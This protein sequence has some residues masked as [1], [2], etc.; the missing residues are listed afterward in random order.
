ML[1][2]LLNFELTLLVSSGAEGIGGG[3]CGIIG[4]EVIVAD[5]RLAVLAA[6]ADSVFVVS[7]SETLTL[8]SGF[9]GRAVTI[10]RYTALSF[11][12]CWGAD[13][14]FVDVVD[15]VKGVV[16]EDDVNAFGC[17]WTGRGA[18]GIWFC[19]FIADL[20]LTG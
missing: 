11:L 10:S 5:R 6:A 3:I 4:L 7:S 1:F 20:V 18:R 15:C 8:A 9:G 19:V 14:T 2:R 12:T 17:T 13:D 16:I